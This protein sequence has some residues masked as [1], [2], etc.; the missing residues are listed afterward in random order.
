MFELS[1]AHEAAFV[2]GQR[3]AFIE[4]LALASYDYAPD[5]APFLT[6]DGR[7][8][9]AELMFHN[10]ASYGYSTRGGLFFWLNLAT[11]FGSYFHSDPQFSDVRMPRQPK[12]ATSP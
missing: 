1:A 12:S 6:K 11:I 4:E 7:L 2:R 9:A 10:A 5:D 8:S 3:V